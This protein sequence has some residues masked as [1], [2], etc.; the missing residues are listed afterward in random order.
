[1]ANT[2]YW[3]DLETSG[4]E[5]KWD[6]IVQF[7]GL[8][9][10]AQLN[11]LDDE[12]TTYVRLPDDVLPSPDA[13]LVTGITPQLSHARGMSETAALL[14]IN[15]I[16]SEPGTCVAG[17]NSLRFDDEFI[18]YSFFR[19]LL[20]PYA[21]EWQQGNSRW[22]LIDLVRATGALRRDGINWPVDE[23]GL[24]VYKLEELTKANGI[25]H[26]QAHDAMSDVRAT[27]GLAQLIRKQQPKL[28]EYYFNLRQ[29]KQVRAML[30]PYGA[31][32]CV[33]VS[34]MYPRARF[35]VAPVTS[36]TRHPTNGNSIVVVDLAE[37]IEPLLN[38]SSEEIAEKL[39]TAG[40]TERPPLKEIR[41]NR[42]PF[43]AP[44]E[45]L[46]QENISRCQLDMNLVNERARR[47]RQPGL[48]EKIA[49]VYQQNKPTPNADVDAGLYDG[50]LQEEDRSRCGYL[51]EELSQGRWRDVD[52]ADTRLRRLAMRMKARSFPNLLDESEVGAWRKFVAGKLGGEGDWLSMAGFEARLD[53]LMLDE[54]VSPDH[55]QV[56]LQLSQYAVELK[57]RYHL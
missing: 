21:R 7:A 22:D 48:A 12:F 25:S 33:H 29:K 46:T 6:R 50:F 44:L 52:F 49:R 32:I 28:F 31:R 34:G 30:E 3:Y 38:W 42:C 11:P 55:H 43:V 35:G 17:Y 37:D 4:I 47:L 26:G 53:E 54:T 19:N 56:L 51:H 24:P 40:S 16:F 20:D 2:F 57:T 1:M 9:T 14:R 27:V 41:I 10:D 18:R 15:E 45:V 5:P 36:V 13:S 8:R 39:F 23:E